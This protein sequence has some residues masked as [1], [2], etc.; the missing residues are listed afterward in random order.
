MTVLV[1]NVTG[2]NPPMGTKHHVPS[3]FV[4]MTVRRA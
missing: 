4:V 2:L 1:T 3:P